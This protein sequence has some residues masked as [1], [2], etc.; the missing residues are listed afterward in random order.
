MRYIF[1]ILIV[2]VSLLEASF[3]RSIRVGSFEN[4]VNA[5]K[6]LVKLQNYVNSKEKILSYQKKIGFQVKIVK[7][8]NYYM[9]VIEPFRD[10]EKE[11]QEVV[12][13]VRLKYSFAYVRKIKTKDTETKIETKTLKEKK[14]KKEP[15][16]ESVLREKERVVVEPAAEKE[17]EAV[18]VDEV[19]LAEE[20]VPPELRIIEKDE[21]KRIIK[22]VENIIEKQ[23]LPQEINKTQTQVEIPIEKRLEIVNKEVKEPTEY[24]EDMFKRKQNISIWQILLAI[25]FLIILFLAKKLISKKD[26]D[27]YIEESIVSISKVKQQKLE[28]SEKNTLYG[29]M[30]HSV[31]KNLELILKAVDSGDVKEIKSLSINSLNKI[32]DLLDMEV[33]SK[34]ELL[35]NKERFDIKQLFKNLSMQFLTE[36]KENKTELKVELAEDIPLFLLGD[37]KRLNQVLFG[38]IRSFV[39]HDKLNNIVIEVNKRDENSSSVD[40]EIFLR[41][42]SIMMSADQIDS[43]LNKE[44]ILTKKLIKKMN[45]TINI[46]AKKEIGTLFIISFNLEKAEELEAKIEEV[47]KENRI[48]ESFDIL[49]IENGLKRCDSDLE[50]Y[51][52]MLEEFKFMYSNSAETIKKFCIIDSFDEAREYILEIKD[53]AVN[54]G[55]SKLA[56]SLDIMNYELKKKAEGNWSKLVEFYKEEL[57]KLITK[58]DTQLKK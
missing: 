34:N 36:F 47:V 1:I 12:D 50:L 5:E 51:N 3:Y 8:G 26:S 52:S 32:N 7:V 21:T 49:S 55:A 2:L 27:R 43:I 40:L 25:S 37:Q 29:E 33:I 56:D 46:K 13:I 39:K 54:I 57:E 9:N 16:E 4:R 6:A 42:S 38:V 41:D 11:L 24:S 20:I 30:S 14:R 10:E 23:E 45:G 53:F 22:D 28:L 58:I 17:D 31:K 15:K 44:L 35:L 18:V 19:I 48:V